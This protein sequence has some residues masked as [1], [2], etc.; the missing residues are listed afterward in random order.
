[1]KILHLLDHS[2]P[3]SDGYAM[4]SRKILA[5]VRAAGF[6]PVVLTSPKHEQYA[7]GPVPAEETIDGVRHVRSGAVGTSVPLLGELALT[8]RVRRHLDRLVGENGV[9]LIHAHS[10]VLNALPALGAGRRR[11]VPVVYEIRAFWEDAAVDQGTHREWGP[12]YRLIRALE[13]RACR[14]ADAVVTICQGLRAD[15]VARGIPE[16]KITVVPNAVDPEE[17]RPAPRDPELRARWGAGPDDFVV[18]FLGSFYHYEGLDLL[19]HA[20]A[21]LATAVTGDG[22][23]VTGSRRGND[24]RFTIHDSR[25]PRALLIGG[26]QEDERLRALAR[27]LGVADRVT[28]AG[29]IPHADVPAAYAACDALVLPRKSMRLTELVTPLKPLEAM[30]LGVPVIASDVGGHRELVADGE[31]GLLFPA[32]DPAALAD[33]ILTLAQNPD[34]A[35]RLVDQGR[36]WVLAE[37]TWQR[38]GE[39]YRGLYG[40]ALGR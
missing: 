38:N 36:R 16:D 12:R 24:S 31:T 33:R 35:A 13:T 20:L 27:D 6:D 1:M 37:R 30:V 2:L 26:G 29:R 8:R 39:I 21:R 3:I 4:R 5:A 28:F 22:S 9:R 7:P 23:P 17:L 32:G 19:L 14:R 11:G 40:E 15:L 34:L 18:G 25:A 10:P